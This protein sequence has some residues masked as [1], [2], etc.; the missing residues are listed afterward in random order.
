MQHRNYIIAL[1]LI[2]L[3][4]GCLLADTLT[5]AVRVIVTARHVTTSGVSTVEDPATIQIDRTMTNGTAA[6]QCDR[7][8]HYS[9][10]VASSASAAFD[11]DGSLTDAFGQVATFSSIKAVS[12][13]NDSTTAIVAIGGGATDV[14]GIGR[15]TVPPSGCAVFCG[16]LSGWPVA[17][18]ADTIT[19]AVASGSSATYRL[20][21]TGTSN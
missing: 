15:I 12:I 4:V 16:P 20:L 11:L 17:S 21:I 1:A 10:T 6:N 9:G 8:Y 18:G 7:S 3:S 14:A 5:T 13:A 19:V 2:A